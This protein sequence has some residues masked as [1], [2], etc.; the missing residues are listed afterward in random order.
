MELVF[1]QFLQKL[2]FPLLDS[3][4][5]FITKLG[6]AGIIWII[7]GVIFLITK[8]NLK[9][10]TATT[11]FLALIL[12][13]IIGLVI[14]KPIFAR[15]RPCWIVDVN[16]LIPNPT[17]YSFPSGH[18]GSSFA[19]TTVIYNYD[20]KKGMWAGLLAILIAFSRMYHFVHYPSDIL[21][22]LVL[23]IIC[24]LI[25]VKIIHEIYMRNSLLK[26]K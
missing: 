19:A 7:I 18:T 8:D 14:L 23:G 24:G 26:I 16:L 3:L 9:K 17:D 13:A 21:G 4:M 20:K 10:R 1:L 6:N 2:R 25:A 15:P 11:I 5:T 22:G 12:F